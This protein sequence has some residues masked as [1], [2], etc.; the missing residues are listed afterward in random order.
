MPKL[1]FTLESTRLVL[2]AL[3]FE[4]LKTGRVI[5]AA[6]KE[7]VYYD[8]G[9]G[10]SV[11]NFK[12]IM[13]GE[14]GEAVFIKNEKMKYEDL[15]AIYKKWCK[16]NRRGGGVLIGSSINEFLMYLSGKLN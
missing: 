10:V 9:D 2:N 16:E 13:K 11:F 6:N 14:N 5:Y 4:V 15:L 1:Y 3:G 8:D 7:P 12:G